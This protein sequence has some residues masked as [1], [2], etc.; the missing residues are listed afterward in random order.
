[1][2]MKNLYKSEDWVF[3][4]PIREEMKEKIYK[5]LKINLLMKSEKFYVWETIYEKFLQNKIFD[6]YFDMNKKRLYENIMRDLRDVF[7]SLMNE[8]VLDGLD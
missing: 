7:S 3:D 6:K 2:A 8:D 4:F 5:S 1:M